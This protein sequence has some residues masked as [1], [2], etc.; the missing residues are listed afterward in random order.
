M[1]QKDK[2]DKGLTISNT[3]GIICLILVILIWLLRS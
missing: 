1:E 2:Y 3:L